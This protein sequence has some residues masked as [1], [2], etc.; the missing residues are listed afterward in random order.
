MLGLEY[1]LLFGV[2][3]NKWELIDG[4]IRWAFPFLERDVAESHFE[5]WTETLSRWQNAGALQAHSTTTANGS[6]KQII[7]FNGIE[8]GLYPKPIELRMPVDSEVFDALYPSFWCR[9]LWPGQNPGCE[10]GW[11]WSQRHHD[12]QLNLWKLFREF[13]HVYGGKQS[14]RVAIA[15]DDRNAV[16]PDQYYFASPR[17]ECMIENDYFQG[18]PPLI[19]EVF[20]PAGRA[21]D[22]GERMQV[23]RRAGVRHLSLLDPEAETIDEYTLDKGAYSKTGRYQAGESF[24]PVAFPKESVAV[25][26]LFDT[27]EKRHGF[28]RSETDLEPVPPWLISP[29]K[30]VGLEALFFFGHPE[31][32]YEIW[33]N[34]APCMLAFGSVEEAQVRFRHFLD[35]ICRWE[36]MA[37]AEPSSIE[38]GID[39]A[40]VGRFRLIRRG[41]LVRLDVAIDARNYR[42]LL[43]VWSKR[44]AW[45][46]GEE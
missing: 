17:S 37:L 32:R 11:E 12:V 20:S 39:I 16:E 23:Y 8:M 35:E 7:Q 10:T 29:E 2:P 45:D 14:G 43:R 27:Q 30:R 5:A 24:Q 42:E 46:W 13:C 34:R 4:R 19:A 40:E 33:N 6:P 38:P 18:V 28:S 26:A 1:L 9:D 22:E 25:D 36:Q 21:L 44:E 41:T 15:L 31:R 3:G